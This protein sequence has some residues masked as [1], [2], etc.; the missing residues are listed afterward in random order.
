MVIFSNSKIESLFLISGLK[1]FC[2][3]KPAGSWNPTKSLDTLLYRKP[4]S[5]NRSDMP[6]ISLVD[7]N[8]KLPLIASTVDL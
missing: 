1:V 3:K 4:L 6:V 5:H 8:T 2:Y 7:L